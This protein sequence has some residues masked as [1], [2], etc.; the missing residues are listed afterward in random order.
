MKIID[1]WLQQRRII[2]RKAESAFSETLYFKIFGG[3]MFPD[4]LAA[5]AFGARDYPPPPPPINLTLLRHWTVLL[6]LPNAVVCKGPNHLSHQKLLSK[7]IK[8]GKIFP[9]CI[10]LP[11]KT[12]QNELY[13]G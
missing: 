10:H 5:R 6:T 11:S 4:P 3:S 1:L 7:F 2:T 13:A 12:N 8:D 9:H